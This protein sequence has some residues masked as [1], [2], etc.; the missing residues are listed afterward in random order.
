MAAKKTQRDNL[1]KMIEI[2]SEI[3]KA[4][5]SSTDYQPTLSRAQ[6]PLPKSIVYKV[7]N[8]I[9]ASSFSE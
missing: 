1:R 8:T 2:T 9:M 7:F 5:T 4:K 3:S 6:R